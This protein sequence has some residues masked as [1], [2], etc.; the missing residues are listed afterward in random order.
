MCVHVY[1]C[2]R[3]HPLEHGVCTARVPVHAALLLQAL[4]RGDWRRIPTRVLRGDRRSRGKQ[5]LF[6]EAIGGEFP[7]E[8]YE[9]TDDP[10]VSSSEVTSQLIIQ[11]LLPICTCTC[12]ITFSERSTTEL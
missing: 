12:E 5:L 8:Y 11:C 2:V 9:E 4:R 10:E 6:D 3:H 7:P 1:L